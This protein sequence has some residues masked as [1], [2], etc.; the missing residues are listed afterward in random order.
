MKD[1][2]TIKP[3]LDASLKVFFPVL[4]AT[5]ILNAAPGAINSN[6]EKMTKDTGLGN[7]P[8]EKLTAEFKKIRKIKGHFDGGK[9]NPEVDQWMGRKHKLMI[10][11]GTRLSNGKYHKSDI[12]NLLGQPDQIVKKGHDL[13]ELITG[14][15]GYDSLTTDAYEFLVYYWRGKHDFLF[16]TCQNNAYVNSGWWYA[17]E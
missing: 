16:L 8:I 10:E 14:Q 2:K 7:L 11:L 13:F 6:V 9:W 4:L 12:N 3:W 1:K 15:P 17:G 5:L